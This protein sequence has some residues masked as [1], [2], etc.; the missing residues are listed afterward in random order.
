LIK[1]RILSAV[2]TG[3]AFSAATGAIAH[4]E[5]AT[6]VYVS[7][8]GDGTISQFKLDQ[9]DGTL[10][11]LGLVEAG[12]MVMPMAIS[13]D[14]RYLYAAIRS[15]PYSVISYLIDAE[16]GT[17]K[18]I[19]Q[20]PLADSMAY[21]SA[22][23]TG[24]YLFGASYGGDLI[25]VNAIGPQGFVQDPPLQVIKTGRH[26]HS[27]L[28]DLS[29]RYVYVGNLGVD[30]VLQFNF[31]EKTGA[32]API[33]TGYAAAPKGSGPRHPA[34]SP[35]NRHVY[36]LGEL[37]GTVTTYAIDPATGAL[38][39]K[40]SVSSVPSSWNFHPGVMDA[41]PTDPSP[42]IWAAD[43]RVSPNGRYVYTT[44]RTSS[45]VTTFR[46]D[47]A[48]GTLTYVG[49]IEVEKQPRGIN[50]DPQGKY[51]IVSGEKSDQIGIYALDP[52]SGMPKPLAKYPVGKGA[53][54]VEVVQF[55]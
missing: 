28:P 7:N 30:H 14:R 11:S 29:N 16:T 23:K 27:I 52:E 24:R 13:P 48:T 18:P 25:S 17:L 10:K 43:I 3:A 32:L 2:L 35:D 45:T 9:N 21:I 41:S 26:A 38:T 33:G 20:A 12:K 46:A 22:D 15:K 49:N 5:P 40:Q 42:R 31:N 50:L 6:Y 51:L 8:A 55:N 34:V 54:W 19:A 36:V 47:P 53:N 37:S 39:E 44:E 4:A 1:L